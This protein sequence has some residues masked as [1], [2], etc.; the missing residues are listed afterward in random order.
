MQ[1]L[2]IFDYMDSKQIIIIS[3]FDDTIFP[4]SDRVFEIVFKAILS[5]KEFSKMKSRCKNGS[6]INQYISENKLTKEKAEEFWSNF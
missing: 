1:K 5:D 4:G 2:I 3:D 6:Y